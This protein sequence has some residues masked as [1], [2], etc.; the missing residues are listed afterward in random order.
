MQD[1]A[2]MFY[3]CGSIEHEIE[4]YI[5][6]FSSINR[7]NIS[8]RLRRKKACSYINLWRVSLFFHNIIFWAGCGCVS[9]E[10]GCCPDKFTPS[11]G[12]DYQVH[13]LLHPILITRYRNFFTWSWLPGTWTSSPGPDYQVQEL[14]HLVLITRYRN[15]FTWSWL[16]CTVQELLHLVLITRYMNFFTWSWLPVWGLSYMYEIYLYAI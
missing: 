1:L 3:S 8:S 13:E 2:T 4:I 6:W 14:L 15:F 16:P 5:L 7:R 11:P 12:P 10:F 9:T